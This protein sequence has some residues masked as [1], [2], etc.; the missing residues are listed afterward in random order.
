[1][2]QALIKVCSPDGQG[3]IWLVDDFKATVSRHLLGL[4]LG[5]IA[6]VLL[7]VLMGCFKIIEHF[8]LPVL[9]FFTKVPPTAMLAVFFVLVGTDYKMY[10]A[11]IGFGVLPTLTQAIYQAAKYDVP[12]ELVSKTFSCVIESGIVLAA[13]R[14]MIVT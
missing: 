13:A 3:K 2:G 12:Q 14:C 6:S 8:C 11:M 7:G 5:V 4:S 9:S 10:L 1:M